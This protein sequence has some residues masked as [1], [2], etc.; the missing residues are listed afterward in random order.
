M[1]TRSYIAQTLADRKETQNVKSDD[2]QYI[3]CHFDGYIN[4]VGETLLKYYSEKE[5]IDKIFKHGDISSLPSN[6]DDIKEQAYKDRPAEVNSEYLL[7]RSLSG[8]IMIEYVYLWK[9]NKWNVSYMLMEKE[10]ESYFGIKSY[11]TKFLDLQEE[12]NAIESEKE[13]ENE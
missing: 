13:S 4:G 12:Y 8:D 7:M 1:S 6:P 10:D 2:L 11:Q 9:D 3:Y 5:D